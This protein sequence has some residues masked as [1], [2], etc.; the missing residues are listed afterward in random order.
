MAASH[1]AI[2]SLRR[3]DPSICE[4][5]C[6]DALP[7]SV[8]RGAARAPRKKCGPCGGD[9]P[10]LQFDPSE[11]RVQWRRAAAA[12]ASRAVNSRAAR[13]RLP[14]AP[15][16]LGEQHGGVGVG[17]A[18]VHREL[19][20]RYGTGR[21]ALSQLD[22]CELRPCGGASGSSFTA[23]SIAFAAS[24]RLRLAKAARPSV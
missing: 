2:T 7:T 15:K 20:D 10:P 16:A 14:L 23:S 5:C 17:R 6:D 19:G 3:V 12:D 11:L 24:S 1:S 9:F 13:S 4:L 21:I 22:A 8:E 18:F